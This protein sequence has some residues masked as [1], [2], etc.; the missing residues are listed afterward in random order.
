MTTDDLMDQ[1]AGTGLP[2]RQRSARNDPTMRDGDSGHGN[3]S[4]EM[5][6]D[7]STDADVGDAVGDDAMDAPEEMDSGPGPSP[8]RPAAEGANDEPPF[9]DYDGL[10][11]PV[12]RQRIN[13]MS[14]DDVRRVAAYERTHRGRK[15]LLSFMN[16]RLN[17]AE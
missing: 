14:P 1:A 15:T 6:S 4:E 11:V 9:N 17:A 5:T 16:R 3:A 2:P 12:I 7:F 13:H 8:T 10:T